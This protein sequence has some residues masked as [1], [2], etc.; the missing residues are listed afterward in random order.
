MERVIELDSGIRLWTESRGDPSRPA[1]LLVMGAGA[2]GLTWPEA[3][4]DAL[5]DRYFVIR[6]DHRDTG[7]STWAYEQRPYRLAEL[8]DDALAV[9]D[10]HGVRCAHLV[11]MSMG[12]VLV[13]LLLA[14]RPERVTRATLFGTC[15][16]SE[17]PLVEPDGTRIPAAELPGPD[18]RLLEFWARPMAD[19]GPEAELERRVEHWRLLNGDQLPF[20]AEEFRA[21]ERRI[22]RHTGH[23]RPS[24][25]H[26]L[27][28]QSGLVRTEALAC[29]TVP[30]TVV[31]A[32]AD[33]VWRPAHARHLGQVIAGARVVR[34]PGMGHAISRECVGA[35]TAAICG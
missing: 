24:T 5:A 27:A 19:H 32:P 29:N 4:V 30:V 11:G 2:S 7:R 31:E 13:Q 34:V 22:I 23:H 35:L 25:A 9:L 33:P 3:L 26:A 14:D 8:A 17:A 1:L 20:H 12:G 21:L 15:A 18:A 10:A 6:Y 16:L 28:D